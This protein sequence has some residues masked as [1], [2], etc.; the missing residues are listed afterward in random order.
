MNNVVL[1]GDCLELM[2]SIPDK[3]IDMILCDLPYGTTACKWDTVIPFEPL[4]KEYKRI[5]KGNGAIVLT[6]SQPFTSLLVTSNLGMFK[7][8]WI[9]EKSKATGYLN[10]KKMPMIAH[11]NIVIFG[12]HKLVYN[13]QKSFGHSKYDK[14]KAHRPTETY[15]S[16]IATLVK[17]DDG[18]RY[19]RTVQYF[20]TAESEGK[21]HPTQKPVALFEYLIKT[22]TNEGDLVL[23]N[24]AGS[25]TTAIAC[26][27]TNR[28][29]ILMEKEPK[30]YQIIMERIRTHVIQGKLE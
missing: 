29:Y 26:L 2:K 5:I 7:Y 14:G 12:K 22:Y 6:A 21:L 27:N 11:E 24:C 8:E 15:G 18:S 25:G 23:D 4:W 3:S 17:C 16:Q 19:P 1:L 30:Y 20:V 9:W 10:S 28:K 13:A